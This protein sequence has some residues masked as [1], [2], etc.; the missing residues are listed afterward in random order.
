MKIM[1]LV[2]KKNFIFPVL[3]TENAVIQFSNP[4]LIAVYTINYLLNAAV[5]SYHWS[6][7]LLPV[8]ILQFL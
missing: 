8:I 3:S 1:T 2:K 7:Y 4:I 6:Y 5:F